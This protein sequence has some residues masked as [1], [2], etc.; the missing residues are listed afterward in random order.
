MF[1]DTLIPALE[2]YHSPFTSSED[3]EI[4]EFGDHE[5]YPAMEI[6]TGEN[7]QIK[8]WNLEQQDLEEEAEPFNSFIENE[9]SAITG[10]T[11]T[12][13]SVA[14]N[15]SVWITSKNKTGNDY[16]IHRWNGN[17]WSIIGG[18]AVR[19]AVAPDGN[20][21]V[22]NS[23]GLIFRKV[24]NDWIPMP[25]LATDIGI[26]ADNT[27]WVLGKTK[28]ASDY[29]IF[30]WDGKTWIKTDGI[31][32]RIAVDPNGSPWVVNSAGQI[33]RRNGTSWHEAKG[34]GNFIDVGVGADNTVW[35][36]GGKEN[37]G[38]HDV[39]KWNA[40][41]NTWEKT[42]GAGTAI[43][44]D[45]DGIPYVINGAGEIYKLVSSAT[46]AYPPSATIIPELAVLPF[47]N[48]DRQAFYGS[49]LL[50]IENKEKT[51][52][53]QD[54]F[55]KNTYKIP[56][57]LF[58]LQ[59]EKYVDLVLI[60]N[61][62]KKLNPAETITRNPNNFDEIVTEGLHQFQLKCSNDTKSQHDGLLGSHSLDNL[63]FAFHQPRKAY[64]A[65]ETVKTKFEKLSSAIKEQLKSVP[66]P[67]LKN[68][69]GRNWYSYRSNPV[70]FG[71][72][73]GRN[74]GY[75]DLFVFELRKAEL[76]LY[77]IKWKKL[78]DLFDADFF[79]FN[80]LNP[81]IQNIANLAKTY[82][83]LTEKGKV[84]RL[85]GTV[86]GI[87]ED[88]ADLREPTSGGSGF[89]FSGLAMD[90]NYSLNPYVCHDYGLR[91]LTEG[92]DHG[93]KT[94]KLTDPVYADIKKYRESQRFFEQLKSKTTAEIHD[95]LLPIHTAF[96][97]YHKIKGTSGTVQWS[98]VFRDSSGAIVDDKPSKRPPG[99]GF[100][101]LDKDMVVI[102]RD[103]VKLA[104]GALDFGTGGYGNGDI[105]HFDLRP[106]IVGQAY[107]D[108]R[109]TNKEVNEDET[110][111]DTAFESE[112]SWYENIKA[113]L[114]GFSFWGSNAA[115]LMAQLNSL[116]QKG[117]LGPTTLT[118]SL[119][120]DILYPDRSGNPIKPGEDSKY[121]QHW[122]ALYNFLVTPFLLLLGRAVKKL[123]GN[124]L[125][126]KVDNT[127]VLLVKNEYNLVQFPLSGVGF[128]RYTSNTDDVYLH[129]ISKIL[130]KH[131]DNWIE[132][133]VAADFYNAIQDFI[134]SPEG[135]D[136]TVHY[137]DVS[138][139]DPAYNLGHE[140]HNKGKAIDIHYFGANCAE[141]TGPDSYKK[142]DVTRMNVFFSTVQ[143]YGFTQNYSYGKR[144]KH[145]GN[146]N[147][148]IHKD[149]F[150][151]ART[152]IPPDLFMKE[153]DETMLSDM[154]SFE[155]SMDLVKD[156]SE[157]VTQNRS[158]GVKLGW[159]KYHD[160]IND[161]L[162][163]FTD[164]QNVCLTEEAFAQA[165]SVWQAKQGF[166]VKDSEGIIGPKTWAKMK[167]LLTL[168]VTVTTSTGINT[169]TVS[170]VQ[171]YSSDIER[172]SNK[173]KFN[174]NIAKGIIAAESGGN[175]SSGEGSSGY[176][177]L[178]Q[179][180][181]DEAQLRPEVSI[182]TGISHFIEFRDKYLGP[183]ITKMG[184]DKAQIDDETFLRMVLCSY[185][186]GHVTVLKALQYAK[187]NGDW[188]NWFDAPNYQRA[189]LFSGGY[190]KYDP[191]N[192]AAG[193]SEMGKA[194]K[195]AAFYKFKKASS[196]T[197]EAD[198]PKWQD[199]VAVISNLLR[200]WVE[201][202]YNNTPGYLN[203]I[204][205]YFK[206][207]ESIS[208]S[209]ELG[210]ER[211]GMEQYN[212]YE[213]E[214]EGQFEYSAKD[215]SNAIDQNRYYAVK[216]GWN[217]FSE[218]LN[219]LLLPFSGMQ[220]VSLGEEA[221]AKAIAV[222]QQKQ[223]FSA[224]ESDGIIGPH[225]WGI[226]KS[227]FV[228]IAPQQP[229]QALPSGSTP[230]PLHNVFN[231]NRWHAQKILDSINVGNIGVNAHLKFN[232]QT[233]LEKIIRG[234][235][236]LHV[237]PKSSIIQSL[238]IIYHIAEQAKVNN[239]KEIM[240][241]SFIREAADDG[242]CTGH[243]AGR[244]IDINFKG[245]NFETSSSVQMVTNIFNYLLSLP[246][247]YN[248]KL[249]FGLPLQGDFFG[250]KK[251]KK[252][253]AVSASLL[254]NVALGQLVSQLG[255]VFPDNDNHLH[256]QVRW[257]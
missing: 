193:S 210:Y 40:S 119:F 203:K 241:G 43:S 85:L 229:S 117:E 59:L 194:D 105:M 41:K 174:P 113:N 101:N 224:T 1:K 216:L 150:H 144:Y 34:P 24:G 212:M 256:I 172:I 208:I 112:T 28:P 100:L 50:S 94:G 63:G 15:N 234:E 213:E 220:N 8:D 185:N 83:V 180:S 246:V 154:Y 230:P 233:Q 240:I 78:Q 163:P 244:C 71:R 141:F 239:Y 166:S 145:S 197:T 214:T 76:L 255:I 19:I 211:E 82:G 161:L 143:R 20:P 115:K 120:Y 21:W 182:E 146:N 65:K 96:I 30:Y 132:P 98:D 123:D 108:I 242:T 9:W 11:A 204:V 93:I 72:K 64:N 104:W 138:A 122:D 27:V 201:T 22:V 48:F 156:W 158:Q 137:G 23:M 223:G 139:Y 243:C 228:S 118:N 47:N 60:E 238:P 79:K 177:G 189:L 135:M 170:K 5:E 257:I 160:Q 31:G 29:P 178:M 74:Y 226:L 130:G 171:L 77:T 151:I 86:L 136:V 36:L 142:G 175:S 102:L 140:T 121:K 173:Y 18:G 152:T 206:Y 51:K 181:R 3:N 52:K 221:F 90:I 247:Q 126:P 147:Q 165:V 219:D 217:Q 16:S 125:I 250:H 164:Q 44:V 99:V 131:G 109:A 179:A 162:V 195:D 191:C 91:R 103:T 251:L 202:R 111:N 199:A 188:R 7:Y 249:G 134:A 69:D 17:T 235:K 106:S 92:I 54:V 62:Y 232:P 153:Q 209:N 73:G 75:S 184:I 33:F 225:S 88:H 218:Q 192:K 227:K 167:I 127:P 129:P 231:F 45:F 26:G 58:L 39:Y 12:D 66:V 25:G 97:E 32:V 2:A 49:F 186:A 87:N 42:E 37:A 245:G 57:A 110:I 253:H 248:K 252:F 13:I 183:R 157:A 190:E 155:G 56:Y 169:G 68:I 198:P 61:A 107:M 10:N 80:D 124:L 254:K 148:G 200:C 236:V 159:N 6:E 149:H 81:A 14:A 38:N 176:K 114:T 128:E 84:P 55:A 187:E 222:W 70:I 89:H 207:F 67:A 168:P 196:W 53:N 116:V 4:Q 133:Q 215:W 46:K 35:A 205:N 237:N 95:I